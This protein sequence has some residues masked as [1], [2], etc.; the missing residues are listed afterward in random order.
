MTSLPVHADPAL[1]LAE[2]AYRRLRDRLIVL[3]IAPGDP[4]QEGRL[5]EELGV[6]RTPL[7]EAM[8]RLE[9]DHLVISYPR[10]GTFATGV[11]I[12]ELA[13]VSEVR[14]LLEPLAARK[15][16]LRA[17]PE[18]RQ[19]LR[20]ARESIDGLVEG[21][22]WREVMATDLTVHR[23]IYRAAGNPHLED[24]L[25]RLDNLATRIWSV[26][27]DRLPDVTGHIREH[28][29][30]LDAIL[31]GDEGRAEELA[32]DHVRHFDTTVRGVI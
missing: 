19:A 4:L 8:K 11:D 24:S 9:A 10:R 17:D 2:R 31:D 20:A 30:L 15:A 7:R 22:P 6:G 5:A 21:S 32:V 12:T 25:I 1:S 29:G 23:L 27:V 26:V 13:T 16:A 14:E 18:V 3:D 28:I